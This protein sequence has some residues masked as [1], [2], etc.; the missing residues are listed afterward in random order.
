MALWSNSAA[1]V[2]IAGALNRAYDIEEGRPWW[3]VRLT[4][5]GLTLAL[6]AFLI[7]AFGLVMIAP[8]LAEVVASRVGVG[9]AV[10]WTW[11]LLQWPIVFLLI[12]VA[13][14]VVNYLAPDAEQGW[15]WVTPG[16]VLATALWLVA[17]R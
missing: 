10:E 7:V 17:S 4:A 9:P 16:A 2:S 5:I 13:L 1:V 14:A 11:K 3:R 15:T 12:A 6:A 8:R